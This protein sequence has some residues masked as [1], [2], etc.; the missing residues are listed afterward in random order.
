MSRKVDTMLLSDEHGDTVTARITYQ[1]DKS[2]LDD[3][4]EDPLDVKLTQ[5]DLHNKNQNLRQSQ[6]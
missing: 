4:I 1:G 3:R 6:Q 2:S 5:A